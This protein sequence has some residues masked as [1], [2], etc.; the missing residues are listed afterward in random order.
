MPTL[1]DNGKGSIT[2][3]VNIFAL[4]SLYGRLYLR[5]FNELDHELTLRYVYCSDAAIACVAMAATNQG[6]QDSY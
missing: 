2:E 5:D 3:C 1:H 4:R 6:S